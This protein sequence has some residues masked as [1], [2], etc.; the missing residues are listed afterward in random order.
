MFVGN[1]A[2]FRHK[3]DSYAK[4]VVSVRSKSPAPSDFAEISVIPPGTERA[5]SRIDHVD[6][7]DGA[8]AQAAV[9]FETQASPAEIQY[10]RVAKHALLH[11]LVSDGRFA[12]VSVKSS[13][14][15]EHFGKPPGIKFFFPTRNG[16]K[17]PSPRRPQKDRRS[18]EIKQPT[19]FMNNFYAKRLGTPIRTGHQP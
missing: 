15:A 3:L 1:L 17:R 8:D 6:V 2:A 13:S 12:F 7:Y 9:G 18:G 11:L 16:K 5:G 19:E 4:K 10:F 14:R